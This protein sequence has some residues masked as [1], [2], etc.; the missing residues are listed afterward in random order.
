MALVQSMGLDKA[1]VRYMSQPFD[2]FLLCVS[3]ASSKTE[4]SVYMSQLPTYFVPGL[5][6]IEA[7]YKGPRNSY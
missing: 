5:S 3:M 6:I 1:L 2:C 7:L 4:M